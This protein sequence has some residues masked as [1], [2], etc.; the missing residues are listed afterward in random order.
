MSSI[1]FVIS[2][3]LQFQQVGIFILQLCPN[4]PPL[5]SLKVWSQSSNINSFIDGISLQ[6]Y[7][8]ICVNL[9]HLV[10]TLVL[11]FCVWQ[12][13]SV[14]LRAFDPT[15]QSKSRRFEFLERWNYPPVFV[16]RQWPTS[17]RKQVSQ[18]PCTEPLARGDAFKNGVRKPELLMLRE[19]RFVT[20]GGI[21]TG[22][23][24][25]LQSC[26]SCASCHQG[27]HA[28][29]PGAFAA[30]FLTIVDLRIMKDESTR[31]HLAD[32]VYNVRA[33]R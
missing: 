27:L 8:S 32:N 15:V 11:V 29:R 14:R 13:T 24:L 30:G 19:N 12:M 6:S 21:N 33:L 2:I 20:Q 31:V 4:T 10:G 25:I 1:S 28:L 23:M 7:S 22:K 5:L 18:I 26:C 16:C 9:V 17:T 3:V